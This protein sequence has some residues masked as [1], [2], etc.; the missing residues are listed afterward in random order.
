MIESSRLPTLWRRCES[1]SNG[2]PGTPKNVVTF[3]HFDA[4]KYGTNLF[5][6]DWLKATSH[7]TPANPCPINQPFG[8]PQDPNACAP[9]TEIYGLIRNTF[10][11]KE[12]FGIPFG[13]T[14][15]SWDTNELI[16]PFIAAVLGLAL[17]EAAYMAEIARAG[18]LS[19]DAGQAGAQEQG[20][21]RQRRQAT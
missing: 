15:V 21:R 10:G 20:P 5:V 13:P 9:Y 14:L 6:I 8:G 16:T 4:W 12:I 2:P 11:W 19:V 3:A 7:T 1:S 17:N 18:I